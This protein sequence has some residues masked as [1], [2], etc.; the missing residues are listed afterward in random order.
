L[1]GEHPRRFRL[2]PSDKGSSGNAVPH[3]R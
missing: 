3:D 2:L 1:S